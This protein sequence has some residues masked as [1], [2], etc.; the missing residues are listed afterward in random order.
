MLPKQSLNSAIVR[1]VLHSVLSLF[2]YDSCDKVSCSGTLA[3]SWLLLA[4]QV[5][6]LHCFP[7]LIPITPQ[8]HIRMPSL[9]V[10]PSSALNMLHHVTSLQREGSLHSASQCKGISSSQSQFEAPAVV[11]KFEVAVLMIFFPDS[12]P[13]VFQGLID[14][15]RPLYDIGQ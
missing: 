7:T 10:C 13:A 6:W 1:A 5:Y 3:G 12:L 9:S 8:S 15:I 4:A 14:F 2:G 11:E